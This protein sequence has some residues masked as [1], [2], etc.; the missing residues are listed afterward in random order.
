MGVATRPGMADNARPMGTRSQRIFAWA[1]I[2]F[3]AV[4]VLNPGWGFF[5]FIPDIVP[6]IGNLDE[7]GATLLVLQSVRKLGTLRK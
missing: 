7:A 1:G 2:V 5:E 3:G 4:Y 6:I